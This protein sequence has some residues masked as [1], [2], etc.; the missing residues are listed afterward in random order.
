MRWRSAVFIW[1]VCICGT[2]GCMQQQEPRIR[3]VSVSSI[4]ELDKQ[5]K[6]PY[7][8]MFVTIHAR[9]TAASEKSCE[10]DWEHVTAIDGNG[11]RYS[12]KQSSESRGKSSSRGPFGFGTR[13]TVKPHEIW[14]VYEVPLGTQVTRVAI[15]EWFRVPAPASS[16]TP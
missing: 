5:A 8:N 4:N 1:I 3:V 16:N 10:F 13:E 15:G 7:G 6:V 2:A 9:H 14:T 12:P 11:R